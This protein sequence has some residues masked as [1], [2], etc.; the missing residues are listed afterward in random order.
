[1]LKADSASEEQSRKPPGAGADPE[2][3]TR[4]GPGSCLPSTPLGPHLCQQRFG[5]H[6]FFFLFL[7]TLDI[8]VSL[9]MG[10]QFVISWS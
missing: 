3:T 4:P 5:G 8:P 6:V 1:M 9:T 10:E 2:G 7:Q